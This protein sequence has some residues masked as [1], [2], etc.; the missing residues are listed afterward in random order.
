MVGKLKKKKKGIQVQN[1]QQIAWKRVYKLYILLIMFRKI[2]S[3]KLKAKGRMHCVAHCPSLH[4]WFDRSTAFFFFLY[5]L[6]LYKKDIAHGECLNRLENEAN[7]VFRF[8]A[9]K[10]YFK[11]RMIWITFHQSTFNVCVPDLISG[12]GYFRAK[13]SWCDPFKGCFQCWSRLSTNG[14]G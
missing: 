1:N 5:H 2:I 7:L 12:L 9:D 14:V 8:A 6:Q 11:K 4:T 10:A 13:S 3:W